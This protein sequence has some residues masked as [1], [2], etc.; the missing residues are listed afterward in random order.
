MTLTMF[1]ALLV[2]LSTVTALFTEAVKCFLEGI[3]GKYASNVVVLVVSI[4]VG[5]GGTATAYIFMEIPFILP[6]I[7]CMV[8]MAVA[9]WVG[10]MVGYDKVIQML[11][12]MKVLK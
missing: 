10:S 8:L 1:M 2:T 4:I 11:E 6:N 9:V 3:S 7:I 5:I 12:Q